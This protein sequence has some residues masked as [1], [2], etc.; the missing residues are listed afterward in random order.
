MTERER[1]RTR[2]FLYLFIGDQQKCVDE[3]GTLLDKY[4]PTPALTTIWRCA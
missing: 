1:Y 3:Y 4:A 2:G